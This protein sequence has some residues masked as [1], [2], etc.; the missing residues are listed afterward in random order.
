MSKTDRPKKRKRCPNGTRRNKKTGNCQSKSKSKIKTNTR[1][2][3]NGTRRNKK[4]GNCESIVTVNSPRKKR[5][6]KKILEN[7][8]LRLKDNTYI[9]FGLKSDDFFS[10]PC[11]VLNRIKDILGNSFSLLSTYFL[12]DLDRV[13]PKLISVE[14]DVFLYGKDKLIYKQVISS[15][16]NANIRKASYRGRNIT[17]KVLKPHVTVDVFVKECILHNYLFC[18]LRGR[19]GKN[20]H[21]PKIEFFGSVHRNNTKQYIIGMEYLDGNGHDYTDKRKSENEWFNMLTQITGCL[22]TLQNE[23]Q[24]MHRDLHLGNIMYKKGKITRWYIIDF[25][26]GFANVSSS[27]RTQFIGNVIH[28]PYKR[29]HRFNDTHDMRMLIASILSVFPSEDTGR[30]MSSIRTP[31]F[32]T[33]L[34][35]LYICNLQSYVIPREEPFFH[36]V[37]E[38]VV[39]I[40]DELFL[41]K[42]IHSNIETI[43]NLRLN[44]VSKKDIMNVLQDQ[45]NIQDCYESKSSKFYSMRNLLSKYIFKTF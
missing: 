6:P 36:N 20:A 4:T 41:P 39:T 12:K 10:D 28:Y 3:P 9:D 15:G 23:F 11:Y 7:S 18:A 1:R 19:W 38:E 21:I 44:G 34:L 45:T 16:A 22:E 35:F 25:G 17:I 14:K 26:L 29:K 2:C 8:M 32:T 13:I 31:S 33:I 37:Y 40:K 43:K 5:N 27:G 42:H 24:F 30:N